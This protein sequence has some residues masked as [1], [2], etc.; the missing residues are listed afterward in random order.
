MATEYNFS[1]HAGQ[2]KTVDIAYTDN[3]V[4]VNVTGATLVF[5]L[6]HAPGAPPLLTKTVGAGIV[7][8]NGPAGTARV[9]L[10]PV[11]TDGRH[12]GRYYYEAGVAEA[13]GPVWPGAY[14][15][16]TLLPS[17]TT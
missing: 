10:D 15:V 1:M 2:S 16:L 7:V 8:Q 9:T 17:S 13:G 14:G 5:V 11:D 12:P 4:P 3:G 6:A